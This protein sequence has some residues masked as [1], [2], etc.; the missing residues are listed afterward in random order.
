V[1]DREDVVSREPHLTQEW[2]AVENL[3][4]ADLRPVA[5]RDVLARRQ[6]NNVRHLI[7]G[8]WP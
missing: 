4:T 7:A 1:L 8:D 2:L 3:P 5:V 6:E